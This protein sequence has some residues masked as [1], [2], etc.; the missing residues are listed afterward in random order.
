MS[1]GTNGSGEADAMEE[2]CTVIDELQCHNQMLEDN[3]HNIR[4][5]Q[6]EVNPSEEVEL[7]YPKYLLDEI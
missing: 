5:R 1:K 4:H 6:Q 3:I 7:L 2:I